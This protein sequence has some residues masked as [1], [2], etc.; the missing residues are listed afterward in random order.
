MKI[1]TSVVSNYET[2]KSKSSQESDIKFA[3]E[4]KNTEN[5]QKNAKEEQ[6]LQTKTEEVKSEK[7]DSEIIKKESSTENDDSENSDKIDGA[8]NDLNKVVDKL[9]QTDEK[10]LQGVNKN[11]IFADKKSIKD[12]NGD[13]LIDNNLNV[14]DNKDKLPKMNL[15]TA[16][17]GDGQP[18]SSFMNNQNSDSQFAN[19]STSA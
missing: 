7:N 10:S 9:R 6:A 4:L 14:P 12:E 11:N 3:D 15:N 8:L 2:S 13:K 19:T 5:E 16:F 1:E 17:S 18:F